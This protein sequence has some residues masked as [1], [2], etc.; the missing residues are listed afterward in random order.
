MEKNDWAL[1]KNIYISVMTNL[2][3]ICYCCCFFCY[4]CRASTAFAF[5]Y[6]HDSIHESPP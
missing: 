1:V 3:G 5:A 4:F 2:F 6:K